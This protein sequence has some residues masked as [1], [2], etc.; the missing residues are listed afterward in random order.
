MNT[1]TSPATP[2]AVDATDTSATVTARPAGHFAP[3]VVRR[4][5]L[6]LAALS[7]LAAAALAACGGGGA[8]GD[9]GLSNDEAQGYAADAATMPVTA[10]TGVS[11]ATVTLQA[12]VASAGIAPAKTGDTALEAPGDARALDTS[13]TTTVPCALGGSVSWVASGLPLAQLLNRQLDAGETF[14]ISYSNCA[15][16]I[17]GVVL[18]GTARVVVHAADTTGFDLSTTATALTSTTPQGRFVLDGTW[19]HQLRVTTLA[20]G[21]TERVNRLATPLAT[22]SSTVGARQARYELRNMDWTTTDVWNG[23]GRP[24]S[25]SHNGTLDL[26]AS[27][28][29]RPSATLQVATIGTLVIG[30]DGLADSGGFSVVVGGDKWS[31]TYA[32][33]TVTIALDLA[34]N[35]SVDRTWTLP[36]LT[37]HGEAG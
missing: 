27:T 11:A 14:D 37:F 35:G 5:S 13:P 1:T 3:R 36:R 34:N 33:T 7:T 32:A 12:A 19:R 6:R 2:H 10:G 20:T 28:P 25:R 31:V 9:E 4:R 24:V 15:T 26:F 21:G 18:T 17:T 29:R 30:S 22:L 23:A 16:A 8:D